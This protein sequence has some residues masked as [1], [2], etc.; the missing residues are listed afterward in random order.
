M[1]LRAK[2]R[3]L[4]AALL[5]S[6]L[7]V[8]LV[9][10]A[11]AHDRHQRYPDPIELPVGFLPEGI[12]IG[13]APVAYFGSRANGD[14]YA[15]NLKTGEGRVISQGPGGNPSVGLK[16]DRRGLLYV[17]GGTAGTGRVVSVRSGEILA[18]YTFTPAP[19]PSSM[20]SC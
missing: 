9:T 4:T 1:T 2:L 16:V 13:R 7:A 3:L 5:S 18:S 10:P 14:I 20:T 6:L 19:R 12:T 15:A 17:A 8:A 11:Q